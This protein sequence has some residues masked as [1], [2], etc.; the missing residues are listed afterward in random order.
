MIMVMKFE[1][2]RVA[3]IIQEGTIKSVE[4]LKAQDLFQ[5]GQ[6]DIWSLRGTWSTIDGFEDERRGL[7][8]K[9]FGWPL[10]SGNGPQL[11]ASKKMGISVLE[12]QWN[13]FYQQPYWARKQ[14]HS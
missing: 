9:E 13:K 4:S 8:T 2:G 10:E 11:T 12:L 7:Q 1:V 5:L 6:K 3:W 14:I